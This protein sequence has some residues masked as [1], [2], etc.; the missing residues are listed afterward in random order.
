MSVLFIAACMR[1][2]TKRLTRLHRTVL[3]PCLIGDGVRTMVLLLRPHSLLSVE[4]VQAA[5]MQF[6]SALNALTVT[7]ENQ[8]EHGRVTSK[9]HNSSISSHLSSLQYMHTR[10]RL[11]QSEHTMNINICISS[12][13]FQR[14]LSE[15]ID[16]SFFPPRMSLMP[17]MRSKERHGT[18]RRE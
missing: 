18:V 4:K 5:C 6:A 7:I 8:S 12:R 11:K 9:V 3:W 1:K 17:F 15:N 14:R 13:Y 16:R 10:A 2:F